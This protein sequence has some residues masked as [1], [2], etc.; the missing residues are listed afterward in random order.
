MQA[1]FLP[2]DILSKT[3]EIP[4][5]SFPVKDI[6]WHIFEKL[7][8]TM[9]QYMHMIAHRTAKMRQSTDQGVRCINLTQ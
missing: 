4:P 3:L 6:L 7:P 9:Q 1:M 2:A 8:V 5:L